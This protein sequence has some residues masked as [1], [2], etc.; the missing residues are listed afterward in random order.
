[1][2]FY[3]E[4]LKERTE[5]R[6][7]ETPEGFATYR[8]PQDGKTVYIID[9]YV[10]PEHR[11]HGVASSIADQIVAIAK[12]RGCTRLL[13]TVVPSNKGSTASLKVLLGYGMWLQSSAADLV[14]FE[15]SI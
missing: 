1:V 9:I 8:F 12:Q 10:A 15:K 2:S 3:A 13:G 7:L 11:A 4:Y 5:D 14:V 6:I